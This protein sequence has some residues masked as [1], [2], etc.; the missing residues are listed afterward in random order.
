[1]TALQASEAADD[2]T[3]SAPGSTR[4][5][6]DVVELFPEPISPAWILAGSPVARAAPL[7]RTPDGRCWTALWECTSGR[8]MW[9]YDNDETVLILEG[10]VHVTW[11]GN[12]TKTLMPGDVAL[13]CAG[14]EAE[15][16]VSDY[17]KKIAFLRSRRNGVRR[18][19]RRVPLV[20]RVVVAA[21]TAVRGSRTAMSLSAVALAPRLAD[22][23]LALI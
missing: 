11:P 16:D 22:P 6:S 1:M 20:R 23:L 10:E 18:L 2:G 19:L 7:T 21:R 8:F 17:V 4:S 5:I 9:R 12:V 3:T 14:S 13:F 15:W